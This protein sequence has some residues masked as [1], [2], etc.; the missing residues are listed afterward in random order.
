MRYSKKQAAGASRANRSSL[1]VNG[2][3]PQHG[4]GRALYQR[5]PQ[6]C[7]FKSTMC[8]MPWCLYLLGLSKPR[9]PLVRIGRRCVWA[10]RELSDA[11]HAAV[12][13]RLCRSRLVRL[14]RQA[15][16]YTPA[17]YPPRGIF[18]TLGAPGKPI[19][20]TLDMADLEQILTLFDGLL[21]SA[22]YF[23]LSAIGHRCIFFTIYLK[24]P[25]IFLLSAC[26]AGLARAV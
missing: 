14:H 17:P 16:R 25:Q 8:S 22:W 5:Y 19:K 24:A 26:L 12:G 13:A 21:Q 7:R 10:R 11:S 20:R 1:S 15:A 3:K 23:P 9:A 4:A 6:S 18:A 2:L